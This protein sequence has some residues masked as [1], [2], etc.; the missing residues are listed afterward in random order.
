MDNKTIRF[1]ADTSAVTDRLKEIRQSAEWL[2]EEIIENSKKQKLSAQET[3]KIIQEQIR[4]LERQ[5]QLQNR[6]DKLIAGQKLESGDLNEK[7]YKRE[8]SRIGKETEENRIQTQILRE[9]VSTLKETSENEI[10]EDRKSVEERVRLLREKPDSL[11]GEEYLRVKLQEESLQKR[12]E[13]ERKS[14]TEEPN[15]YGALARQAGM[16]LMGAAVTSNNPMELLGKV[17]GIGGKALSGV[18]WVGGAF[19]ALGEMADSIITKASQVVTNLESSGQRASQIGGRAVRDYYSLG[20][21]MWQYGYSH[22]DVI[23]AASQYSRARGTGRGF[24]SGATG[25]QG[26]LNTTSL[27]E[28]VEKTTEAYKAQGIA[29]PEGWAAYQY[30]MRNPLR[31]ALEG[32]PLTPDAQNGRIIESV[33]QRKRREAELSVSSLKGVGRETDTNVT[34]NPTNYNLMLERGYG[35]DRSQILSLERLGRGG[36]GYAYQTAEMFARQAATR[37]L[38]VSSDSSLI[39]EYLRTLTEL[40]QRQIDLTGESNVIAQS[41]LVADLAGSDT[42]LQNNPQIISNILGNLDSA[43]KSPST[44]QMQAMV[45]RSAQQAGYGDSYLELLKAQERGLSDPGVLNAFLGNVGRTSINR[46]DAI[47]QLGSLIGNYTQAEML[48]NAFQ[49][50]GQLGETDL[51]ELKKAGGLD[52]SGRA[53]NATGDNQRDQAAFTQAWEKIAD[54][55]KDSLSDL[56][57]KISAA[58]GQIGV[59]TS[60]MKWDSTV[61]MSNSK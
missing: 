31:G 52:F 41:Q 28:E 20:N 25:L 44:P 49:K 36:G 45:F 43:I 22:A 55:L 59:I 61:N 10:R 26:K 30:R 2:S 32:M 4:A 40:A 12:Q 3:L 7:G 35:I 18:P 5:N 16:Q 53:Y 34:N 6:T 15:I 46:E 29:D 21:G 33:A 47:I 57:N 42:R 13:Q 38:N 9:I 11:Q 56:T 37:G 48:W 39:P 14:K 1:S 8:L 60:R 17:A 19:E 24:L 23:D 54:V 27:S 51:E 50:N 58:A